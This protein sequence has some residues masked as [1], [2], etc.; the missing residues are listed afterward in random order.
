MQAILLPGNRFLCLQDEET[1]AMVM[2]YYFLNKIS[3]L[4]E[5]I[6]F[7]LRKR[8]RQISFLHVYH[9]ILVVACFYLTIFIQ[10][11]KQIAL[12]V[13]PLTQRLVIS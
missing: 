6:F 11:G 8:S 5:T 13:I 10:P 7:V 2:Y 12:K 4:L 9:H 3:D 1:S